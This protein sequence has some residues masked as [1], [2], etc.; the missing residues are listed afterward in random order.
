MPEFPEKARLSAG[1]RFAH[2]G[3]ETSLNG[4]RNRHHVPS[5]QPSVRSGQRGSLGYFGPFPASFA[6]TSAAQLVIC[7]SLSTGGGPAAVVGATGRMNTNRW[8]PGATL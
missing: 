4:H 5:V 3:I 6:C 1:K 7:T 2:F 8:S